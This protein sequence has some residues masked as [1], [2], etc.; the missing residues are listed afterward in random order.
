MKIELIG[1][2]DFREPNRLRLEVDQVTANQMWRVQNSQRLLAKYLGEA[3]I[4]WA[5][6]Q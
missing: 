3:L 4:A 1:K 5:E 6:R 2:R